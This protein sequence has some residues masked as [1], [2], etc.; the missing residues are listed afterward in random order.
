MF[1]ILFVICYLDRRQ[2]EKGRKAEG[3]EGKERDIDESRI[4]KA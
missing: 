3:H 2:I 4:W 1:I